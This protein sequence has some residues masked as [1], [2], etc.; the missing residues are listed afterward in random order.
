MLGQE[1]AS[2]WLRRDPRGF[3]QAVGALVAVAQG[4]ARAAATIAPAERSDHWVRARGLLGA[5]SGPGALERTLGRIA[6]EWAAATGT[7]NTDR[8]FALQPSGWIAVQCG[9]ADEL[10][11]RVLE[12]ASL[13]VPCLLFDSDATR[14]RLLPIGRP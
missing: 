1:W 2:T 12:Q 9:G 14:M 8:L 13:T 10:T 7:P 5:A 3:E 11:Q 6:L 4:L